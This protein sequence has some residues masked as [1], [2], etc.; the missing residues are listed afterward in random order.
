MRSRTKIFIAYSYARNPVSTHIDV[1]DG[2]VRSGD[3]TSDRQTQGS[4]A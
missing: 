3:T 1:G 4:R 2:D